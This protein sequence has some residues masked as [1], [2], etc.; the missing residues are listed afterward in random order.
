MI[1]SQSWFIIS[2]NTQHLGSSTAPPNTILGYWFSTDSEETAD[3]FQT[4]WFT[5]ATSWCSWVSDNFHPTTDSDYTCSKAKRGTITGWC[6]NCWQN[7]ENFLQAAAT[8]IMCAYIGALYNNLQKCCY[9][10]TCC[11][12]INVTSFTIP[13][14]LTPRWSW[15]YWKRPFLS[16][17]SDSLYGIILPKVAMWYV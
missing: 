12:K 3:L 17:S 2:P 8:H 7:I 5:E 9:N 11:F 6:V 10:W 1:R 14:L 4:Y 15:C 16:L 13:I